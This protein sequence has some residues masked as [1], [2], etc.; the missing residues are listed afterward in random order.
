MQTTEAENQFG[1][2]EQLIV[3]LKECSN[4]APEQLQTYFSSLF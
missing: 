4:Y 2:L 3:P 1:V